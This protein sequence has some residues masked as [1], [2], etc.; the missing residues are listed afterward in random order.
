MRQ[1]SNFLSINASMHSDR[2]ALVCEGKEMTW[3]DLNAIANRIANGLTDAGIKKGDRIAYML[4]NGSSVVELFHASQKIGAAALAI[5]TH[6]LAGEISRVLNSVSCK[7]VFYQ[8]KYEETIKTVMANVPSLKFAFSCD[9]GISCNE[10]PPPDT[11]GSLYAKGSEDEAEV[12]LSED[13]EAQIILTSGTTGTAKIVIRNQRMTCDYALKL[14]LENENVSKP[15]VILTRCPLFHTGG[16]SQMLRA[17]ALGATLVLPQKIDADEI[18]SLIERYEVTQMLMIPPQLYAR[19][20]DSPRKRDYDLS[21]M[22]MAQYTGGKCSIEFLGKIF[23]MFPN[24]RIRTTYGSTETGSPLSMLVSREQIL[25][26]PELVNSVGRLTPLYNLRL[27]NE[28]GEDCVCGEVGELL[29][30]SSIVFDGY[31]MNEELNAQVID[32]DGWFHTEDLLKFDNDGYWY[33]VDRLKDMIK[34]GGENV[35]AQEVEDVLRGYPSVV[36]VSVIG[37]DDPVYGEAVG[38][39]IQ[40]EPNA[41]EPVDSDLISYCKGLLPS[42]MKPRY[43]A[44]I[45]AIPRNVTGKQQ[46]SELRKQAGKLFR[47]IVFSK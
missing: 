2:L 39:A 7:A 46:K 22:T 42:Y 15:E 19:I 13:D 23:D 8:T 20:A 6:F 16:M 30:K 43:I 35:Y 36:D 33:L 24:T 5:N 12:L 26:K 21:S 45:D 44:Y 34:T 9:E 29:V 32:E 3:K 41:Q 4:D 27:V 17:A 1:F 14:A 40:L 18:F 47:P 37:I 10:Y 28:H 38:A 11:L 25:A 31:W